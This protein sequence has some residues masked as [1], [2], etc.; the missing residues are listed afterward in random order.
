[1]KHTQQKGSTKEALPC[2]GQ[3]KILEG[4]NKFN[5]TKLTLSSD[6]DHDT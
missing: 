6:G 1:M 4:L 3:Q 2:N 5:G